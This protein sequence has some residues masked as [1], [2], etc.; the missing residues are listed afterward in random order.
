MKRVFLCACLVVSFILSAEPGAASLRQTGTGPIGQAVREAGRLIGVD[1]KP[2]VPL[3]AKPGPCRQFS[4]WSRVTTLRGGTEIKFTSL[5]ASETR[6]FVVDVDDAALTVLNLAHLSLPADVRN[7]LRDVAREDPAALMGGR[8]MQAG[9]RIG[10]DGVF[11]EGRKLVDLIDIVLT[12][13]RSDV[14]QVRSRE[15][16]GSGWG[17]LAGGYVGFVAG[18]RA[19][20]SLGFKQCGRSCSD[21]GALM[22]LS[23]IGLPIASGFAGYH[24][25][26]HTVDVIVYRT[27]RP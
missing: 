6:G 13:R 12:F 8:W 19:A 4:D 26:A 24:L 17:A 3:P 15:R 5:T 2:T 10:P 27:C 9:I 22:V 21:E 20:V 11:Y 14:L 18:A 16:R 7:V 23:L 25:A 1:P